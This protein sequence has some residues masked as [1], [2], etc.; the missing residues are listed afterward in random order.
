[1]SVIWPKLPGG[2][3]VPEQFKDRTTASQERHPV[4]WPTNW[5]RQG[6]GARWRCGYC[7]QFST[8]P[9]SGT[10]RDILVACNFC[11]KINRVG[12]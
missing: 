11:G 3:E 8:D 12:I 6:S 10:A 9:R 7:R 5:A 1:M 2:G 4:F